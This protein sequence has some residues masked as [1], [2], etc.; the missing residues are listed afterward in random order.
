MKEQWKCTC[1]HRSL[2]VCDGCLNRQLARKAGFWSLLTI[3]T[4]V[5]TLITL[6][7]GM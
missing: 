1:K 7:G 3:V 6:N 2:V 4:T 5:I